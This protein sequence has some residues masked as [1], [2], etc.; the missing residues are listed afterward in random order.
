MNK[1]K[2]LSQEKIALDKNKKWK[3]TCAKYKEKQLNITSN[4]E[5]S[6]KCINTVNNI[7]KNTILNVSDNSPNIRTH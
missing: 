1:Y 5:N 4:L 6:N 2:F 7:I 3:N